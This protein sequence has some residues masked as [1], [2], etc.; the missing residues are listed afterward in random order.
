MVR[1]YARLLML[2]VGVALAFP[3]GRTVAAL[4]GGARLSALRTSSFPDEIAANRYVDAALF[5]FVERVQAR[6]GQGTP[7]AVRLTE[8][9]LEPGFRA[10]VV[11]RLWYYLLPDNP[12]GESSWLIL[13][14]APQG[15][16]LSLADS[17]AVIAYGADNTRLFL[18]RA[19]RGES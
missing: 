9:G 8:E 14:E 13:N 5:G 1:G 12:P 10:L 16:G 7:V 15:M 6:V 18:A 4:W 3:A 17:S 19:P 2:V 11:Q